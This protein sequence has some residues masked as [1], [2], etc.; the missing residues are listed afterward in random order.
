[1]PRTRTSTTTGTDRHKH[2]VRTLERRPNLITRLVRRRLANRRISASTESIGRTM[3]EMD[4][5][6]RFRIVQCLRICIHRNK[7]HA[8]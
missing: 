7:L 1:M 8:G 5:Y 2:H 4:L 6:V 3:S